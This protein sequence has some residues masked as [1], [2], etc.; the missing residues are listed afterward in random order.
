M[1]SVHK[2]EIDEFIDLEGGIISG[3]KN[4]SND[5]EIETGP[6]QKPWNDAS[7]Y[8][9]GVSTTTDRATRYRQDIP[10]F[11]TYSYGDT[12]GGGLAVV[13]E[14]NWSSTYSY[15]TTDGQGLGYSQENKP[16]IL[17]KKQLEEEIMEDLVKKSK[18]K[19]VWGKDY[20]MKT[21]KIIDTIEGGELT[22]NQLERIKQAV[23]DK[24]NN[25]KDA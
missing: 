5:S 18:D 16:T 15:N 2:N 10:W 6:V 12:G 20:D 3:D 24:I 19:E 8:E 22:D 9:K 17:T 4:T 7:D 11:A 25:K 21:G 1:S 13:P 23:L 14:P